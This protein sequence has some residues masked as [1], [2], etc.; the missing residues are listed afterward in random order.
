MKDIIAKSLLSTLVCAYVISLTGCGVDDRAIFKDLSEKGEKVKPLD[1]NGDEDGDGVPNGQEKED[2]TDPLNKD[3]D[4][5]GL[6][7]GLEKKIGTNPLKV[8][9]D[10]DHV[11]D[12][13]EVVGTYEYN[14]ENGKVVTAGTDKTPLKEGTDG[15]MVL[16]LNLPLSTVEGNATNPS[17][18]WDATPANL[19]F[20]P[21]IPDSPE[22]KLSKDSVID[23]LDPYNDSDYDKRP[24]KPEVNKETN[25][26]DQN[27]KYLWIYETPE[28]KIME[29]NNFVY[30]PAIDRNGGFWMSKYEA[31]PV[32]AIE[33]PS[34][35]F[36]T[37]VQK[38]FR[39]I[40]GE[41]PSGFSNADLSGSTLYTV[42]FNNA[43]QPVSGI[44][45]FEAAYMLDNSQIANTWAIKLP[46]LEQ[47]THAIKL[48]SK[49]EVEN[50]ILYYDPQVEEHYVRNIFELQS[51]VKEFTNTLVPLP[52]NQTTYENLSVTQNR[53]GLAYVGSNT[54]GKIG[55]T[56]NTALAIIGTGFIDLRYSISYADNGTYADKDGSI[57]AIGFRAASDYIK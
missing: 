3:T 54:D 7:D 46:A 44:Y 21:T 14:L 4:D 9:T 55:M 38:D 8:D 33:N 20:N 15:L 50:S 47:Y 39:M 23:A 2:G 16:D 32:T 56:S 24:N 18:L 36:A 52:F 53:E 45:G 11:T 12:G 43:K 40:S 28:G 48:L 22:Y 13:I 5:D 57:T 10:G 37:L 17:N 41:T 51:S 35:D 49:N 19:H 1:P 34:I 26:L 6:D 42:N 29:Q 31:R 25:P 27:S 30:V